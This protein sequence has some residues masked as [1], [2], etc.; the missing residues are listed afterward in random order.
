VGLTLGLF[1]VK[2][3][4]EEVRPREQFGGYNGY[5]ARTGRFFPGV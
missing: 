3:N 5:A 4:E 2:S 1:V